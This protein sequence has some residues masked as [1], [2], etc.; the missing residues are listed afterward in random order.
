[1]SPDTIVLVHS[2]RIEAPR[3]DRLTPWL[4][5]AIAV[6]LAWQTL[7]PHVAPVAAE[8]SREMTNINIERVGGRFLIDGAIPMKCTR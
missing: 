5:V 1:M 8:A 3:A 7:R 2:M 4:I 6:T